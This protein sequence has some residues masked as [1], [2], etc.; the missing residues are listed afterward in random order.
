MISWRPAM[1]IGSTTL[2]DDHKKLIEIVNRFECHGADMD[3]ILLEMID[4]T[5]EHFARE[6][7]F[8]RTIR[9]PYTHAH[10][11]AHRK[12]IGELNLLLRTWEA[13]PSARQQAVVGQISA[14]LK[15]WLISHIVKEDLQIRPFVMRAKAATS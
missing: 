12:L 4:Y 2:D 14:F 8:M 11:M 9:Y 3:E 10:H 15:R 5:R 1:S 13:T 6:E 7:L